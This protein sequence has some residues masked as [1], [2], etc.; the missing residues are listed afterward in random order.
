VQLARS[1]VPLDLAAGTRIE[2]ADTGPGGVYA[3]LDELGHGPVRFRESVR[4]RMPGPEEQT[5]LELPSGT[6]VIEIVRVAQDDGGPAMAS[7]LARYLAGLTG[8][9]LEI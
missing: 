2:E 9:A 1:Y 6:P 3:R 5:A 4:A 8:P 7:Q